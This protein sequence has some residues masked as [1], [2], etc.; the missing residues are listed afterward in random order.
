MKSVSD[1]V[2]FIYE[3]SDLEEKKNEITKK[4]RSKKKEI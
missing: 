2:D 1:L 3:L 4:I